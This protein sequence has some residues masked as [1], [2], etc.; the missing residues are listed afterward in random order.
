MKKTFINVAIIGCGRVASHYRKILMSKEVTGFKIVG[1]CDLIAEKAEEFAYDFKCKAYTSYIEMLETI[2]PDFLIIATPSGS[3]Y[4]HTKI[5][6][7]KGIHV[8]V[9]KPLTMIPSHARELVSIAEKMNLMYAVAFQNRLNPAI[10]VLAKAINENRFGKIVTST[11]RLRWCRYQDY[12]NDGWHG[13]WENDGGVIN[14]QAIHHVDIINWLMGPIISVCAA[15]SNRLNKL[16]A[17]DTMVSIVKFQNGALGTIEATTAARPQDFEAS[18]SIVGEKGTVVIGGIALNKIETWKFI[19]QFPEDENVIE[20][21]SQEVPTGY[22]LSHKGILQ[23]AFDALLNKSI[24]PE[25]SGSM[26]L[27]TTELI[28]A[29]YKSEEVN[30]WVYLKDLPISSRLGNKI[31]K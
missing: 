9:E 8:L 22:G 20:L 23:N 3:H 16:E 4:E 13:T 5:A 18:I 17:E 14:Q 10:R 11:V 2:K 30:G 21:Y 1:V 31:K 29:L 19:E 27:A 26:A 7:N 25:V 24:I 12:Y 28:H 6:L 15:S